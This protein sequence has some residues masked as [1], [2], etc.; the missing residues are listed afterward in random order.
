MK[1]YY[2]FKILMLNILSRFCRKTIGFHRLPVPVIDWF[3]ERYLFNLTA[4]AKR[5]NDNESLQKIELVRYSY[6][7]KK[8]K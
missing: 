2:A 4:L 7:N 1:Y 5:L 8:T 3:I 6:G